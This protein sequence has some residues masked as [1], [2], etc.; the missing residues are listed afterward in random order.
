MT[1]KLAEPE[2]DVAVVGG[3][4]SGLAAAAYLGRNGRSVALFE[5]ANHLGGR[6]RT[7]V[8]DGFQLN[9]G[10]HAL[11]RAGRGAVVLREL[12]VP[13][14]GGVPASSGFAIREGK[15]HL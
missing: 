1:T 3:G 11:Y 8:R 9:L 5:K 10:P 15:A 2:V 12:G 14:S 13:F 4:I 7:H 6:A